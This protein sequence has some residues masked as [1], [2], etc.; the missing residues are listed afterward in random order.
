MP[1]I[2]SLFWDNEWD[3][4]NKRY[5]FI[6]YRIGDFSNYMGNPYFFPLV[7]VYDDK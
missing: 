3:Y 4:E 2:L 1:K 5:V 7:I 6:P